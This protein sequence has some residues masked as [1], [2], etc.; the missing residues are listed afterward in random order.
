MSKTRHAMEVD[1]RTLRY[2]AEA[3]YMLVEREGKKGRIFYMAYELDAASPSERPLTFA[4]NGGPGAASVWL[5]LGALGPRRVLLNADGTAPPPP[6][7]LV[8]N[9]FTWLKFTDLVFVD[10][11]GT[12]YSRTVPHDEETA[13]AFYGVREDIEA[14]GGLV[15]LFL[16]RKKRWLSPK[17][18][19]GE[20]YGATR[21]AGLSSYLH[22]NYGVDLNGI[23]LISPAL[24]FDT[25]L[26]GSSN[27]LPFLLYLPTYAA[28]AWCH[29]LLEPSLQAKKLPQLLQE[30]E[31]FCLTDYLSSLVQGERLADE[32][33][34]RLS[35]KLAAFTALS[36]DAIR[37]ADLRITKDQFVKTLL[38][39][40]GRIVGRMDSTI[41]GMDP[42]PANPLKIY[43]P[44]LY[45]LYGPFS[46]AINAYIRQE[47]E[48]ESD[49]PYE[50]L[51]S[52]VNRKWDWRSGL[53]FG[54]GYIDVSKT[55]RDAMSVNTHLQVFF[56]CG[57]YDLATPYFTA[58]YT[59][60]HMD[61]RGRLRDRVSMA[62]YRAGH[63]IFTHREAL[64]KLTLDAERF[65]ESAAPIR[66]I[67]EPQATQ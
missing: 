58:K 12:G 24:D 31:T 25:L 19:V 37:L 42:E 28:A 21:A 62:F 11:V 44:S 53:P 66:R 30:V 45:T 64:Q 5:H 2:T 26:F 20:S 16:S 67:E 61:P 40:Q 32:E 39:R 46:G 23:V 13:K 10:P 52:E 33:K 14:V 34:Q 35:R 65:Y 57:Y 49:V 60:D 59:V 55:L 47:L 6:A 3:G 8:D 17:F 48:F 36:E 50:F 54:Q 43:D 56:A 27:D 9:P 7:R 1:G 38:R 63:M 41:T 4:F 15:R 22:E 51:S 29:G 18:L